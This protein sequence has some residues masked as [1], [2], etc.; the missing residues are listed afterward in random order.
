MIKNILKGFQISLGFILGIGLLF[1]IVYAVGFHSAEEIL[2]GTFSGNYIFQDNVTFNGN[3]SG[4]S[5]GEIPTGTILNINSESCPT[6]Y[7][8]T[9]SITYSQNLIPTMTSDTSPSGQAISDSAQVPTY[10][11]YKAFDKSSSSRWISSAGVNNVN[12]EW[13]G[14]DFGLEN[15][16]QIQKMTFLDTYATNSHPANIGID[17]SNDGTNWNNIENFTLDASTTKQEFTFNNGLS[18]RYWRLKSWDSQTISGSNNWYAS[19]IEFMELESI[20]C[21]KD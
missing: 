17:G 20:K 5:S 4:I 7:S 6:S 21:E 9:G 14:Y 8:Q 19:E 3:V 18:Y 12:Q 10:A 1:G 11:S 13:I 16:K 15:E 2:G